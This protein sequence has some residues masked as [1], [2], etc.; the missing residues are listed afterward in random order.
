M[1]RLR[2]DKVGG[3]TVMVSR[4]FDGFVRIF[5]NEGWVQVAGE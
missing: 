1:P 2:A 4:H 5:A 3:A